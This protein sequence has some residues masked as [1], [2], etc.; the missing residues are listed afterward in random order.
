MQGISVESCQCSMTMLDLAPRAAGA[1]RVARQILEIGFGVTRMRD[2]PLTA[3]MT[4]IAALIQDYGL[5]SQPA[6]EGRSF[7]L[8]GQRGG[9]CLG[10]KIQSAFLLLIACA[11]EPIVRQPP[12]P[13]IE[14]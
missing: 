4:N 10:H 6:V 1:R 8:I 14:R 12:E 7:G 13:R 2:M 9:G 3:D 11:Q 5:I